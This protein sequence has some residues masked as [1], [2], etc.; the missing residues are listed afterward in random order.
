MYVAYVS[1]AQDLDVLLTLKQAAAFLLMICLL[2]YFSSSTPSF[3]PFQHLTI[4][5]TT[6]TNVQRHHIS[7]HLPPHAA[8]PSIPLQRHK[9]QS[10]ANQHKSR[11][12]SRIIPHHFPTNR[13]RPLPTCTLGHR[14]ET[15]T[16]PRQ[17]VPRQTLSQ[18]PTRH[19]RNHSASQRSREPIYCSLMGYAE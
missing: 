3:K 4:S 15:Q 7:I 2:D 19:A 1:M 6:T 14:M 5:L 17:N 9:A 16:S 13:L 10:N 12:H 18:K 11:L 8:P